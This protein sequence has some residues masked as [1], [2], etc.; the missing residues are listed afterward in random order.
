[1]DI[2]NRH[3]SSGQNSQP[4]SVKLN[5]WKRP[6]GGNLELEELHARFADLPIN[7]RSALNRLANTMSYICGIELSLSGWMDEWMDLVQQRGRDR[8][9]RLRP[10]KSR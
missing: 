10:K 7:P 5:S 1:M 3:A 8:N 9:A 4:T 6:V 2:V